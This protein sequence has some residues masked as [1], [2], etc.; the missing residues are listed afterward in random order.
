MALID[1]IGERFVAVS[2]TTAAKADSERW[3]VIVIGAHCAGKT[4]ICTGASYPPGVGIVYEVR[5]DEMNS[6][7]RHINEAIE[8][9]WRVLLELVF[10][11][12]PRLLVDRMV[13]R[14]TA[15][16]EAGEHAIVHR[17][18]DMAKSLIAVPEAAAQL[19]QVLGRRIDFVSV[20]NSR[21]IL[22]MKFEVERKSPPI[23]TAIVE[24]QWKNVME[25]AGI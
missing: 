15:A 16:Q 9:G 10:C 25:A 4:S 20:D 24:A 18:D 13:S 3:V 12:D 23:V 22:E 2:E 19:L 6:V 1:K 7:E 14:A 21:S 8:A 17:I 11:D 5:P